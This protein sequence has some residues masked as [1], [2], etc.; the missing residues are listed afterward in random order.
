MPRKKAKIIKVNGKK[1]KVEQE[2]GGNG[3]IVTLSSNTQEGL[4]ELVTSI[5]AFA[6]SNGMD[7][8]EVLSMQQSPAGGWEAVIRAH[9][10]NPFRAIGSVA[11]TAT[12]WLGKKKKKVKRAVGERRG[13]TDEEWARY[14]KQAGTEFGTE[15]KVVDPSGRVSTTFRPYKIPKGQ[16]RDVRSALKEQEKARISLAK[17][18]ARYGVPTQAESRKIKTE[19]PE[20]NPRTGEIVRDSSGKPVMTEEVYTYPGR[21]YSPQDIRRKIEAAKAAKGPTKLQRTAKAAAMTGGIMSRVVTEGAGTAAGIGAKPMGTGA[22]KRGAG[23][24]ALSGISSDITTPKVGIHP[25][26]G[27]PSLRQFTMPSSNL[28][29]LPRIRKKRPFPQGDLNE[30]E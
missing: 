21:E 25:G 30:Q 26:M 24:F 20:I 16:E 29:P 10:M 18:T 3:F 4:Q 17:E 27:I 19:K 8:V 11:S 9:N 1:L 6:L 22:F 12:E 15:E 5:Q 7:N 23:T 13:F 28:S 2:T 14:G